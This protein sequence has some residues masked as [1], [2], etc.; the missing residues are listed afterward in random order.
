V[1]YQENRTWGSPTRIWGANNSIWSYK[2]KMDLWRRFPGGGLRSD[3]FQVQCVPATN[4][5]VYSSSATT[6]SMN[7]PTGANAIV[8]NSAKTANLITPSGYSSL[9]WPLDVVGMY[10]SFQAD[11]YVKQYQITSLDSTF[12]Y[13]FYSDP[14]NTSVNSS[15][16]PW[17]IRGTMKEQSPTITSVTLYYSPLGEKFQKY[18]GAYTSSGPGNMGENPS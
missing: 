13:A 17:V 5:A 12:K 16:S 7:F 14:N 9:T 18:P 3:F 6:Q 4:L 2:S 8:N 15:S 11:G 10:I 1:N